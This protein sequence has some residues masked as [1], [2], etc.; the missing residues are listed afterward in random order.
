MTTLAET[1]LPATAEDS[2]APGPLH[3]SLAEGT[4][5]VWRADLEAVADDLRGLLCGE[6][7]ARA[8]RFL[9]ERDRKLWM[10]SRGVLRA[11]LGRYLH[12]D[13]RALAFSAGGHGKPA[14]LDARI[15]FN[16]SHSGKLALYAFT[17]TAAV[18]IDV[19]LAR[20]PMDVL[21]IAA[22]TFGPAEA[23]RLEGLDR[24]TRKREFLR[25]WVRHEAALKF[26]GVGIGGLD[27][28]DAERRE[29]WIAE[30]EVGPRAAAAVA[31]ELPPR[32]LRCW[33]W[34]SAPANPAIRGSSPRSSG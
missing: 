4:V 23:R 18:G 33:D 10:R 2:W 1:S 12:E 22:R 31:V 30:L 3:P 15:S 27:A 14:L 26:L 28:T 5:H 9:R 29:P 25:A 24:A 32:E 13:P 8:E 16:L 19:E 17:P 34:L 7:R 20:R 21:A 6:E 11:L